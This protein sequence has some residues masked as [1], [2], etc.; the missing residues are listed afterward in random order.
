MSVDLSWKGV[1]KASGLS[2]LTGGAIVIIF[3]FLVFLFQVQLPLA[4]QSVLDAPLEPVFLF[5]L[6]AFGE[7]L[8]MPGVL[9]LYFSLKDVNKSQAFLGTAV[10]LIAIP[11]FL[12]SRGQV[13][14]L[15]AISDSYVATTD[16]TMRA[17]YLATAHFALEVSGVFA[18]MALALFGVGSVVIGLVMS[19]GVFSKRIAYLVIIAGTLTV[20][21]TFGVLL[22]PL[23]IGTLF[24][25][26]LSGFWQIILGVKLY[27]LGDSYGME[28]DRF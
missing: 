26:I 10:F 22:E 4:A 21:G 7:F 8:L 3:L 27:K 1:Y 18:I 5:S 11:M 12:I 6:A 20:I 28:K 19:K 14:S 24:G 2:L 25:L 17:A 9:G 23:T 13:I 16:A 15:V